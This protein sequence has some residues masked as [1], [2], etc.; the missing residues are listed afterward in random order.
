MTFNLK[1]NSLKGLCVKTTIA[2]RVA[3]P[4]VAPGRIALGFYQ[5]KP[6]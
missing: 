1:I 6:N 4:A 3:R 2:N 5:A